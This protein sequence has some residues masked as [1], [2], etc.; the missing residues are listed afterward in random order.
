[1]RMKCQMKMVTVM[2]MMTVMCKK[3]MVMNVTYMMMMYKMIINMYKLCDDGEGN[4]CD[5]GGEGDTCDNGG[6]GGM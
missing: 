3:N 6:E 1:M 4:L 5:D 2:Y